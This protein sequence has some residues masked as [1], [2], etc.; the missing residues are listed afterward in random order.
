MT[1][2]VCLQATS[3][4][5]VLVV[6][7]PFY[8]T[9]T[10]TTCNSVTLASDAIQAGGM[11][12]VQTWLNEFIGVGKWQL[13]SLGNLAN[14]INHIPGTGNS[15]QNNGKGNGGQDNGY[16]NGGKVVIDIYG[17]SINVGLAQSSTVTTGTI[18]NVLLPTPAES[19]DDDVRCAV[20]WSD[21]HQD[22]DVHV[23]ATGSG[24]G[25]SCDVHFWTGSCATS[26]I[27]YDARSSDSHVEAFSIQ[28]MLPDVTYCFTV[29]QYMCTAADSCANG[30]DQAMPTLTCSLRGLVYSFERG[31]SGTDNG[32]GNEGQNNGQAQ[33]HTGAGKTWSTPCLIKSGK[34]GV[35]LFTAT[36]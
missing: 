4:V 12:S 5:P 19:M 10:T 33:D 26:S 2:T 22:L 3:L 9:S 20:S 24:Q 7:L 35:I 21:L 14:L 23:T 15:G 31:S 34:T 36:S 11:V 8:L 30:L 17:D 29:S 25:Q 28:Q 1:S 18:C 27:D 13:G 16:G 32:I 6:N